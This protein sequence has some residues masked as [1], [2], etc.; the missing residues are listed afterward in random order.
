[1]V[2]VKAGIAAPDVDLFDL[3]NPWSIPIAPGVDVLAATTVDNRG[4]AIGV[5]IAMVMP[6]F[7]CEALSAHIQ[8]LLDLV[9][10]VTG[11]NSRVVVLYIVLWH[12]A[13]I[14]D[15]LLG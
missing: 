15:P 8:E 3:A 7:C 5:S 11:D 4:K 9:E 6:T 12:L 14:F 10:D 1:M 13:V 2:P